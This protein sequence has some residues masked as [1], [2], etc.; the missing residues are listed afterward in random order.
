MCYVRFM[1]SNVL[2]IFSGVLFISDCYCQTPTF[3]IDPNFN[4]EE[5]F[6]D[7]ATVSD[8]LILDDGRYLVGGGFQIGV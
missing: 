5:L 2:L 6:R 8:I 4:T 7:G 1:M 3:T